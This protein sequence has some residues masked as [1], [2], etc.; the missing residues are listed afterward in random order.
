MG[1][2]ESPFRGTSEQPA[3]KHQKLLENA[4]CLFRCP[5]LQDSGSFWCAVE[6]YKSL[7]QD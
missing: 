7:C 1:R 6:G 4:W 2:I 3:C 5:K